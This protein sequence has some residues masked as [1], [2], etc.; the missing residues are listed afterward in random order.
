[1]LIIINKKAINR[2]KV[3]LTE[4]GK[5]NKWLAKKLNKNGIYHRV[6]IIDTVAQEPEIFYGK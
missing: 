4:H 3:V 5:T 2:L 1:M 6:T